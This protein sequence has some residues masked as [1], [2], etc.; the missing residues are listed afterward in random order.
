MSN[1]RRSNTGVITVPRANEVTHFCVL[2]GSIGAGKTTLAA[3]L[4]AWAWAN[5]AHALD[6]TASAADRFLFID[7]PVRDWDAKLYEPVREG[8]EAPD[9]STSSDGLG[10]T[11][12]ESLLDK[13]YAR[14][15]RYG[16]LFQVNAFATRLD[17]MA[18]GLAP[19]P[20]PQTGVRY[21]V[22]VEGGMSR[23]R[24]F[25][26]NLVDAGTVETA[27]RD[28][29]DRFF[30]C[31]AGDALRRESVMVYVPTTPAKCKERQLKRG[32][33]GEK[34]IPLDYLVA[35]EQRHESMMHAFD[36]PVL[37]L[38]E[39]QHDMDT[40]QMSAL[41]DRVMR[42]RLLPLVQQ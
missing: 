32:R 5:S 1:T 4:E 41:A 6:P 36:G 23:D 16:F 11:E 14:P 12:R 35:L 27:E 34:E 18:R 13:F 28:A 15:R 39:L 2:H 21:H 25:F 33:D 3:H 7:E 38:D 40:T 22:V 42:E 26:G 29:Y 9:M 24:L 37:R 8:D 10:T 19:L 20:P 17:Y 31:V 30:E